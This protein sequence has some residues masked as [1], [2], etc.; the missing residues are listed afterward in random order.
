VRLAQDRQLA[1]QHRQADELLDL[2][3]GHAVAAQAAPEQATA[4]GA[5][6]ISLW[7]GPTPASVAI[8]RCRELLDRHAGDHDIVMMTLNYPLANL[9]ALHGWDAEAQACLAV[10]NRFADGLG[11][12]EAAVIVPYFSAGV[13]ALAGRLDNAE[14]LL[15]Q[16]IEN[17]QAIGHTRQLANAARELVRVQVRR[18]DRPSGDFLGDEANLPPAEAADQL[19][20]LALVRKDLSLA[21]DA[22][23]TA[24]QTDSPITRAT[25]YADLAMVC[26]AT[27]SPA[28]GYADRAADLFAAKEHLA[29]QRAARMIGA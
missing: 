18:G 24:A 7:Y 5:I 6:G 8:E 9:Y 22:V 4:L 21:R 29:G 10:A 17:C 14:S 3:L 27:G 25:A 13:E 23:T 2:A 19:G 12:A 11:Y 16:T 26:R 28:T 1:G 15:R 20:A